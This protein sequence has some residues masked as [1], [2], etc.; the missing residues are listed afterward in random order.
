MLTSVTALQPVRQHSGQYNNAALIVALIL[1]VGMQIK[2]VSIL[3]FCGVLKFVKL[4]FLKFEF[5]I[6]GTICLT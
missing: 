6:Y 3:K 4:K 5:S 2:Y 1:L